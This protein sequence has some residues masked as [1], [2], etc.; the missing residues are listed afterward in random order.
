LLVIVLPIEYGMLFSIVLSL[1]HGIYA[2][3]RP[4][5]TELLRLPNTTIWW[6]PT[7]YEKG[8]R[9]PGV[10]VFAP[11]APIAFTNA[12]YVV[13]KLEDL[14]ASAPGPVHL[15][16]IAG[17]GVIDVDYTGSLLLQSTIAELR[18]RGITVAL[19]RLEDPRANHAA[20]RSELLAALGP[21]RV[22]RS[23]QDAVDALASA[24][25]V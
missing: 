23:V 16:V 8:E 14:L 25:S 11:A 20:E 7:Q 15:L 18:A 21:N 17:E 12:E 22:F 5:S 9:L 1:L 2:V 4:P 6:P 13:A 19:A 3:A 10:V 24:R